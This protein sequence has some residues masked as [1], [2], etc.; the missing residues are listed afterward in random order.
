MANTYYK[1][2]NESIKTRY[3]NDILASVQDE[4]KNA[5]EFRNLNIYDLI[6]Q[7]KS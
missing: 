5:P 6:N 4:I 2:L 3:Q 7:E 1:I